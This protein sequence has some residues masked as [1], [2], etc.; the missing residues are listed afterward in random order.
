MAE[1][2]VE[3][4][5]VIN[6]PID[7]VFRAWTEPKQMKQWYSPEGMTTPEASSENHK[8]G[9]YHVQMKM[10]D[11]IIDMDGEYL[12]FSEPNKLVFTWGHGSTT[13]SVD[14]KKVD[15]NKTE[16]ALKHTGFVDEESRAQ[17]DDGWVG[18]FN[19]LEKFFN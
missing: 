1:L 5:R 4:K 16:V 12:E 6:A 18:T 19:K 7:K 11:Q 2:T 13:V 9:K 17:H 15:E 8:G 14:F 10:G 3:V